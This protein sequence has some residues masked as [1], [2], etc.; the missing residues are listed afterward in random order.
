MHPRKKIL[1]T[2][3]CVEFA[4]QNLR[5]KRS[6]TERVPVTRELNGIDEIV[7]SGRS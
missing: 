5:R 2:P 4:G 7:N 1:A 3:M 6:S